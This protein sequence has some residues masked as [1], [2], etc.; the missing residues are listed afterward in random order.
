MTLALIRILASRTRTRARNSR[1][2][3][4]GRRCS[5]VSRCSRNPA[6]WHP[7]SGK[8]Q[9]GPTSGSTRCLIGPWPRAFQCQKASSEA[10]G[11]KR[12][13]SNRRRSA[14]HAPESRS[15]SGYRR[16]GR[17]RGRSPRRADGRLRGMTPS[18]ANHGGQG[19][20]PQIGRL[21]VIAETRT[22][23][24][25]A[26]LPRAPQRHSSP[27][28]PRYSPASTCVSASVIMRVAKFWSSVMR[29]MCSASRNAVA[30][31]G[32]SSASVQSPY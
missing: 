29:L 18:V 24:P 31:S 8:P 7:H 30:S 11:Q 3:F 19:T 28:L 14:V 23:S 1:A 2:L 21:P 16:R 4:L 20:E 32:V 22:A 12:V 9:S 17:R 13:R 27:P 15:I 26:P 6:P 10:S 25:G 5:T